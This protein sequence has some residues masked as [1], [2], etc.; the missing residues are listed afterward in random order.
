MTSCSLVPE[1]TT[2]DPINLEL[3][4]ALHADW[5]NRKIRAESLGLPF[6][7]EPPSCELPMSDYGAIN[8][9]TTTNP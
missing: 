4:L 9:D 5:W 2:R 3:C 7:E 1:D 6:V 8:R